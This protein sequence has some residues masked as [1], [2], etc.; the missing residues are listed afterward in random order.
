MRPPAQPNPTPATPL[1]EQQE[2]LLPR[3]LE[4]RDLAVLVVFEDHILLE[5]GDGMFGILVAALPPSVTPFLSFGGG[6]WGIP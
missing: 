2:V 4:P 5:A 3:L 1:S 6:D